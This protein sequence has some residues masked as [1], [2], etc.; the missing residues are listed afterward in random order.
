MANLRVQVGHPSQTVTGLDGN[1]VAVNVFSQSRYPK[2]ARRNSLFKAVRNPIGIIKKEWK[3]HVP[4]QRGRL[5]SPG[6]AGCF[7]CVNRNHF[8]PN[9]PVPKNVAVV[10]A[11]KIEYFKKAQVL[12]I[13]SLQT[14]SNNS[15]TTTLSMRQKMMEVRQICSFFYTSFWWANCGQYRR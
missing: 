10:A 9:W 12:S 13:S 6:L 7:N 11:R 3:E 4:A 8:A 1:F 5:D 2:P 15:I 14:F